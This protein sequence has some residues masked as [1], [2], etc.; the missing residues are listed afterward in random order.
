MIRFSAQAL[1][2]RGLRR[3]G[4]ISMERN[5]KCAVG[6]CGH[7]QLGPSSC[8][9]T[10]RCSRSSACGLRSTVGSVMADGKPKLAVWKFASCDGCQLACS[11]A[12]TS[13]CRWRARSRSRTSWRRAARRSRAYDLS[14]VEGS[15]TTAEDAERIRRVRESS[16]GS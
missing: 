15:I 2:E 1:M 7:C 14:L 10:A 11:T 9:A 6:H 13:C 12:R 16:R 8:V 4:C 3:T 5:M